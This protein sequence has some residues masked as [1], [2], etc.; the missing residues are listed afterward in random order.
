MAM[1]A[2]PAQ[3]MWAAIIG[4]PRPALGPQ[5]DPLFFNLFNSYD[6]TFNV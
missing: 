4:P 6:K 2:R 5:A 1:R 3:Y